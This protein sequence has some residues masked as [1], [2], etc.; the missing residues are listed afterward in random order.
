MRV[1]LASGS[2][3]RSEILRKLGVEFEVVV[4]GVEE[5]YGGDPA[6]EVLENARRKA[7]V[8]AATA[9]RAGGAV[10]GTAPEEALATGRGGG[11]PAAT[12]PARL[13]VACDT[14]VVL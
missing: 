1:T 10:G 6:V 13:V 12:G 14:D 9:P 4:P 11:S 5:L 3:Q 8:V 7:A 2:P